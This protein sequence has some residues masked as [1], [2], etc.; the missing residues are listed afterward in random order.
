[1]YSNVI[2]TSSNVVAVGIAGLCG[3]ATGN[4]ELIRK[5]LNYL[6]IGGIVVAITQ[7]FKNRKFIEEVKRE[8]LEKEFYNI[9][10]GNLELED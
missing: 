5:S 4:I 6:D 8:F 10:M 2:A 1:M 3:C 9:V 7:L